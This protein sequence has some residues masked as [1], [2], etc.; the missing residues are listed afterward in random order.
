MDLPSD[1]FQ[2]GITFNTHAY[3]RVIEESH[4]LALAE[5]ERAL[6]QEGLSELGLRMNMSPAV[7]EGVR[8]GQGT[9]LPDRGNSSA[10]AQ[11]IKMY[12]VPRTPQNNL[13]QQ[14]YRRRNVGSEEAKS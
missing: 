11:R 2:S 7:M 10:K 9:G 13:M 6:R 4:H 12:D 14:D 3:N 8:G 5:V 1:C